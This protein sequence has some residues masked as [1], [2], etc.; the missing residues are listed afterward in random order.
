M[1]F[2][3]K[4]TTVNEQNPRTYFNIARDVAR[5]T[6]QG[7]TLGFADEIEAGVRSAFDSNKSYTDIVKQVRGQIKDFRKSNPGVAIGTEI[8]G[9]I[10]PTVAAQF[11]PGLGQ[12]ASV[13]NTARLANIAKGAGVAGAEGVIYG[14]GTAEGGLGERL[15]NPNTAISGATGAVLGGA[16]GGLAPKITQEA[17]ELISKGVEVTPG[18]AV[19]GSTL[20]GT[21]LSR[22]EEATG[23][24]VFFLG[25]AITSALQN[26]QTGFNRAAVNDALS[27]I[28]ITVPK[29]LEGKALIKFGQDALEK[30]YNQILPKLSIKN[31]DQLTGALQNIL[32]DVDKDISKDITQRVN[33][34]LIKKIKPAPVTEA[35]GGNAIKT[36]Q[37][38][39]RRMITRLRGEGTEEALRKAD[40][41]DDVRLT[42]SHQLQTEIP[43]LAEELAKL[44]QSYGLFEI[45]RNASIRTKQKEGFSPVDLLQASA[46]SD[47]TKR[48]SKFSKG[49]A[50]M[51]GLAQQ[52]QDVIGNTVPDSGT[53]QRILASSAFGTAGEYAAPGAL[54]SSIP[55]IVAGGLAYSRPMLPIT[56]NLLG[57]GLQQ[58]GMAAA[59]VTGALTADQ[60]RQMLANRLQN[61]Q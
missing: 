41:L 55:P 27:R 17:K 12:T 10:L 49:E 57:R 59:P 34:L 8:A 14:V 37:T 25:D 7:L 40:A 42:I 28:N 38:E 33:K 26:A 3:V 53:S 1:T 50:R 5:A 36:A 11:I 32:N 24:N 52:A 46:K 58:G 16:V 6:T 21:T 56:R 23:K 2:G 18:Q 43:E 51:Q 4:R 13:A 60:I 15:T 30:K 47:I 29:N 22:F 61:R 45:V 44:D 20:G 35:L 19:K 9:A 48:Q 54:A 31:S 39:L